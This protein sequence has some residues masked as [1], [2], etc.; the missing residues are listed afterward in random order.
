ME[1]IQR[2]LITGATGLI[3]SHLARRLLQDENI[4]VCALARD[5]KKAAWLAGLGAE[6]RQG[7]LNDPNSIVQ[8]GE[9]CD[10]VFHAAAWVSERGSREEMWQANVQGTQNVIDAA[11]KNGSQ[12]FIHLSS[13]AVYGS[14]QQFD[15]DE[16]IPTRRTGNLYHDSKIAAE[17]IVQQAYEK[18]QLSVAVARI[19]QVYGPDSYQFTIR[20][21]ELIKAKKMILIDGGKFMCKPIFIEN[22]ID[23][24]LLCASKDQAV[25][26]AIN[27][28]DGYPVPWRDFFGAY[29][30][31]LGIERFPSLPYPLAWT[32]ALL[33]EIQAGLKGKKASFSRSAVN[34][35]RSSNSFSNKKAMR[36][37][38]WEPRYS[39]EQ[40]MQLTEAWLR[41]K[42]YLN[43][44]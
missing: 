39:L 2:V 8:A 34:S 37:L 20:P 17:E 30:R 14:R 28:T 41:E 6:I 32:A 24:L 9:G 7:D 1:N 27:L 3:G 18:K 13:C 36:L 11:L 44:P 16:S 40:G 29:G 25:G 21:V 23:G 43:Q 5:V 42:G 33:F 10:T 38:N 22:L 19:S 26:E 31:M 12:K 4:Q 35:L 15:I